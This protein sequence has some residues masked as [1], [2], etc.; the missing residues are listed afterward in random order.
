MRL[1]GNPADYA[2]GAEGLDSIITQVREQ[3][4]EKVLL[5]VNT[6]SLVWPLI[7][8][9]VVKGSIATRKKANKNEMKIS[10]NWKKLW[11]SVWSQ[12]KKIMQETC[13]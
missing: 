9:M 1:H 8:R 13:Q 11:A 3:W 5:S 10:Q 4:K 6:L 12:M 2:W 7:T